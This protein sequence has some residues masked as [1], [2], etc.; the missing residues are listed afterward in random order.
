MEDIEALRAA[1]GVERVTLI[2]VSYGTFVAQAY[3]ARYPARVERVLLDSVLDVSAWDPFSLDIFRAVPRVCGRSAAA[4]AGCS[5]GTRWATWLGSS[6]ASRG[7]GCA[8]A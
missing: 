4:A 6:L 2:G 8:A 7:A 5:P 3:A 1:L